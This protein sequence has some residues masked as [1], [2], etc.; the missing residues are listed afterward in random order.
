MILI[1][2][3]AVA[4]LL[5][6]RH[7]S[8]MGVTLASPSP[9]PACAWSG[10]N[11]VTT[12][13]VRRRLLRPGQAWLKLQM[14]LPSQSPHS[15]KP[16][17]KVRHMN[18]PCPI[19]IHLMPVDAALVDD[20]DI[21]VTMAGTGVGWLTSSRPGAP[22]PG[23]LAGNGD[24]LAD[25]FG[26]VPTGRLVV[27]GESGS[28]KSALM[29]TLILDLL[30]DRH[31]TGGPVPIFSSL[32]SWDREGGTDDWLRDQLIISYPSLEDPPPAGSHGR[33]RFEALLHERLIFPILDGLD[34]VPATA[35]SA[36][37][38]K[39]NN[40][41]LPGEPLVLT[42]SPTAFREATR[43]GRDR[44]HTAWSCWRGASPT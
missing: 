11:T 34:D 38:T 10:L 18:D 31:Y 39:I 19:P 25:L 17:Q 44:G 2:V 5:F 29:V 8:E 9:C 40:G 23:A 21:L 42:S 30:K 36:A 20:W 7:H 35:R 12:V 26:Q 24:R 28:G 14:S 22:G 15:G 37:I 3:F 33:T 16:R 6:W 13:A 41:L 27:L 43:P 4:A 32:A 1:T